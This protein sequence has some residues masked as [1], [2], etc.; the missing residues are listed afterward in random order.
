MRL[1]GGGGCSGSRWA[2][3]GGGTVGVQD[4]AVLGG[5]VVV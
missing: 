1:C 5:T 3:L 2:V 4:G